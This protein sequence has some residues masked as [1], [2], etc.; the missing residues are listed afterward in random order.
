MGLPHRPRSQTV[1]IYTGIRPLSF[2]LELFSLII[3]PKR[4]PLFF[5]FLHVWK[6]VEIKKTKILCCD[7]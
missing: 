4:A 2:K 1:G 6:V 7:I 5:G 3:Q